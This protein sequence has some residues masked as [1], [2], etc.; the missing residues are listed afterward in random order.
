[1]TRYEAYIGK[2]WKDLGLTTVLVARIR[3][4]TTAECG[5]FLVDLFCLGIKDAIYETDLTESQLRDF[6]KANSPKERC[7][8]LHPACAKKVI[9]GARSLRGKLWLRPLSG[10]SQSRS[11]TLWRRRFNLPGR[12]CFWRKRAPTLR[13]WTR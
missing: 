12:F 7:Q 10:V 3:D 6:I 8:L 9:E 4:A 13:P 2:N 11:R 5:V 1:M